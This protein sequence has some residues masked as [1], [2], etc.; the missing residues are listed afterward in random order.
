MSDPVVRLN[1]GLEG[2]Y[3]IERELGEGGMATVYLAEDLKHDRKVAVETDY[4]PFRVPYEFCVA[5]TQRPGHGS[6]IE[7]R[8]REEKHGI[9]ELVGRI[10]ATVWSLGEDPGLLFG[11]PKLSARKDVFR[12]AI[13]VIRL[14]R[15]ESGVCQPEQGQE[16][17]KDRCT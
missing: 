7:S 1:A 11:E 17:R 16:E 4:E 8:R 12:D 5:P 14:R 2:R 6:S 15:V 9:A 3:A 13:V 10:P